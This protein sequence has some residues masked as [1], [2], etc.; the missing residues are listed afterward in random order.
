MTKQIG[1]NLKSSFTVLRARCIKGVTAILILG[2]LS[3]GSLAGVGEGQELY[4]AYCQICHGVLGEGQTMG[5]PLTDATANRLTDQ[6]LIDV[7]TDGRAGTGMAAWEGSLSEIEIFDIASYIRNLQGRP[8]LV[9]GD[10]DSGPSDD[11]NVIAGEMLFNG[12]A[13]CATCHSYDEKGGSVGPSLDGLGSRLGDDALRQAL[14]NPSASIV[15]GYGAKEVEQ[16]DGTVVRGRFRNDSELAVQ[17]QSED[18]RRWVTY[19]KERVTAVRDLDESLMPDT[20]ANLSVS[21]QEK[22]LAF[23][24]SL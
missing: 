14:M 3:A 9:L 5:K 15:S 1:E 24:S 12:S 17:I 6:E 10:N 7:I 16:E 13:D 22:L 2:A 18:G 8:A 19:F 4:N 20:F 11:P 23:L 21:E